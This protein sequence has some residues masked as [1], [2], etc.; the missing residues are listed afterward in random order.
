MCIRDRY[1][2]VP[3]YQPQ[4]EPVC[5]P[6]GN[7]TFTIYDTYGDGL[8]GS[9]WGGNDGSYYLMQC[10]DTLVYGDVAKEAAQAAIPFM[11]GTA[12]NLNLPKVSDELVDAVTNANDLDN[13]GFYSP[14]ERLAAKLPEKGVGKDFYNILNKGDGQGSRIGEEM[15]DMGLDV[16]LP[17]QGKVS[18]DGVLDYINENKLKY[19]K[20][21][22]RNQWSQSDEDILAELEDRASRKVRTPPDTDFNP[23]YQ[24]YSQK[25]GTDYQENLLTVP[26]KKVD[27]PL[28][29]VYEKNGYYYV[30]TG[31]GADRR[32]KTKQGAFDSAGLNIE[33]GRAKIDEPTYKSSHYDPKNI[34]LTTRTQSM[35]TPDGQS[36][37][38]MDELQSDW[39]SDG[40]TKGYK[41][42]KV[43]HG[44]KPVKDP[45]NVW[46]VRDAQDNLV[47]LGPTRNVTG[48]MDEAAAN[49]AIDE[50]VFGRGVPNAPAKKSW[51]NQ[52]IKKELT[53]TVND[54]KDYFAW[55]GGKHQIDRYQ[56]A[57][58]QNVDEI[59]YE[60][61]DDGKYF[62]DVSKDGKGVYENSGLS[63]EEVE[64]VFGKDI[65]KKIKDGTG[66]ATIGTRPDARTLSGDDLSIGGEGMKNFYDKDVKKRTEKII[67]KLDP[68]AKVEV[69]D[70]DNGNKVW[71]VKITDEMRN[72]IKTTG[73]SMYSVAPVGVGVG[74]AA[75]ASTLMNE[76]EKDYRNTPQTY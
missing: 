76:K 40:R 37:H 75:I 30:K 6:T 65:T 34:G 7:L 55:T 50:E 39:H 24:Q 61:G 15:G 74:G 14:T 23:K 58:R 18:R 44:M 42:D 17:N 16:W 68:K 22:G 47:S 60:V 5:L 62:I 8:A 28:N 53:Q 1:S 12:R 48:F 35:K 67:K 27:K 59:V 64:E 11:F 43:S 54:G 51:M 25:G 36:V 57:M 56:E 49:R 26:I 2:T 31:F 33:G 19:G 32:Y 73:Q 3:D 41:G 4:F 63:I 72:K 66:N 52:G 46:R 70:I 38:L 13:L 21:V 45:Y 20:T 9:L 10:G 29:K 69:I 71:G